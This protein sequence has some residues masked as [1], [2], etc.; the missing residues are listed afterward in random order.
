[1]RAMNKI[2][3][4]TLLEINATIVAIHDSIR[5]VTFQLYGTESLFCAG[6]MIQLES[7]SKHD[8]DGSENVI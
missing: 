1:M 8:G 2:K 6:G 7:L 5:T 4:Q 3:T